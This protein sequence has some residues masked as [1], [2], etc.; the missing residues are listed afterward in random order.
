[1]KRQQ[2]WKSNICCLESFARFRQQGEFQHPSCLGSLLNG[3]VVVRNNSSNNQFF[4]PYSTPNICL[5]TKSWPNKESN[6]SPLLH[7]DQLCLRLPESLRTHSHSHFL[8]SFDAFYSIYKQSKPWRLYTTH[9]NQQRRRHCQWPYEFHLLEVCP[10]LTLES[11]RCWSRGFRLFWRA[12]WQWAVPRLRRLPNQHRFQNPLQRSRAW[13]EATI[14]PVDQ[15]DLQKDWIIVT[16]DIIISRR[17]FVPSRVHILISAFWSAPTSGR[18]NGSVWSESS[19]QLS[20]RLR[21]LRPSTAA[22]VLYSRSLS[23]I[24]LSA[25][26]STG[27]VLAFPLS[28]PLNSQSKVLMNLLKSLL[29]AVLPTRQWLSITLENY[30]QWKVQRISRQH[31]HLLQSRVP[32][33]A[34]PAC[35][36]EDHLEF[37]DVWLGIDAVQQ[38]RARKLV[39]TAE[40]FLN[41]ERSE[42]LVSDRKG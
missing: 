7:I 1:M 15:L 36:V 37:R 39:T 33:T 24:H 31:T 13:E 20:G 23:P 14:D 6:A 28:L 21:S 8:F 27:M 29:P 12:R 16:I 26:L 4:I 5:W 25:T 41:P 17:G 18:K 3:L 38:R 40:S 19:L 34:S 2:R 32:P 9:Q 30:P 42:I 11:G 22:H 35:A 10:M